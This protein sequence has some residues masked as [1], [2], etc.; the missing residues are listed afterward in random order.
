MFDYERLAGQAW[1]AHVEAKSDWAK[2][3]WLEVMTKL[4]QNINKV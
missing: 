3:Y 1:K 2:N 4:T